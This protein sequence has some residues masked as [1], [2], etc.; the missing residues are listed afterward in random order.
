MSF[1]LFNNAINWIMKRTTAEGPMGICWTL[2]STLEDLDFADDLAL[3]S[4]TYEHMQEK[5]TRL[6]EN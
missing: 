6:N 3:L 2:T 1:L 5:T 4:H